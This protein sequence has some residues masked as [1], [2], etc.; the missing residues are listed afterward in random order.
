MQGGDREFVLGGNIRT[1]GGN[2]VLTLT[3]NTSLTL[4]TSGTLATL[5]DIVA[6]TGD[7]AGYAGTWVTAD[8]LTKTVTH[9]L[10]S[11][12]VDVT[13]ID[14]SDATIIM[15]G[16]IEVIDSNN[17]QITS[18]ELPGTSGWRVIIQAK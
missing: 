17:I 7:V 2:L 1:S 14:L 11:T 18:S 10:Q 12:D 4:P 6:G 9:N 15:A 5:D 16:Q 13:L 8:G 3:G